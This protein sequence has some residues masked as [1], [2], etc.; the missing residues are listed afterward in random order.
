MKKKVLVGISGGID[1]AFSA[2]LL[3][4]QGYDVKTI[5]MKIWNDEFKTFNFKSACFGADEKDDLIM[6]KKIADFLNVPHYVI[7]LSVNFKN[8]VLEYFRKEYL[9]GRTPNPCI[10]CN[11]KIKFSALIKSAENSN[12]E[13]DFFATGHYANIKFDEKSKRY[14]LYKGKDILK[15]Q[16]Y[17]LALLSQNQLA[18]LIFPLGNY[19]KDEVRNIVKKL[20]FPCAER[21]ESQDFFSGDYA[22]LIG[23]TKKGKIVNIEDGK[24]MGEHN[25]IINYTVGQR[26][27]LKISYKKPLYVIKIDDKKNI[28]YVGTEKF[29]YNDELIASNINWI[30]F[31]KLEKEIKAKARIRYKHKEAEAI[32]TPLNENKIKVKFSESQ[33]AITPG[34][35]V[36]LYD[37]DF[38]LGGGIIN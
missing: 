28:I 38:V 17:F 13:F 30:A 23:Q 1:S 26:Q 9:S 19:T 6:A 25:G 3:K 22:E 29:L 5:T 27:G 20:K 14:L 18:K 35:F 2:Y 7:D 11:K 8:E 12:I 37:N 33:R 16:S 10:L 32:I 36:V 4:E 15:D 34:Q 21:K 31:D 24:I